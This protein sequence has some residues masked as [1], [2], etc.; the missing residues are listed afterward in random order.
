MTWRHALFLAVCMAT[1]AV[2]NLAPGAIALG[3]NNDKFNHFLAFMV[4]SFL[5]I[6]A[7]PRTSFLVLLVFLFG[8][9]A[10]IELIQATL[11]LGRQAEVLDWVAG[12]CATLIVLLAAQLTRL[13][14]Q[15][16]DS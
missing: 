4:I 8:F 11:D 2:A 5:A 13:A 14:K 1:L 3:T 9:N 6:W 15:N 16:A 10:A 12:A 7:F